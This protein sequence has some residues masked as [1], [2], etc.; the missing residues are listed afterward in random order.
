MFQRIMAFIT[1]IAAIIIIL[2]GYFSWNQKIGQ[3]AQGEFSQ[4]P[5]TSNNLTETESIQFNTLSFN[6]LKESIINLPESVQQVFKEAYV[7]KERINIVLVGSSS[8]GE[9]ENSWGVKA[10]NELEKYYGSD[11]LNISIY[12]FDGTSID[13]LESDFP[14]QIIEE[15]P[16]IILLETFRLEDNSGL[17]PLEITQENLMAFM[18]QVSTEVP[19]VTFIMQPPNP[20]ANAVNYPLEVEELKQFAEA[21]GIPYFDHWEYWPIENSEDMQDYLNDGLPNEQGHKLWADAVINY[22]ITQQ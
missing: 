9:D 7:N 5:G 1:I 12:D 20:L 8:M 3:I 13:F 16:H 10:K 21:Q 15:K 6:E 22:F 2:I 4:S 17:V 11:L 19:E 18:D 14:E